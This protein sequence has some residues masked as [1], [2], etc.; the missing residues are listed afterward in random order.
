V[1]RHRPFGS[2]HPYSVDT[3][4]RDPVDPVAGRPLTLGVRVTPE[5]DAVV[6]QWDDGEHVV[7]HPLDRAQRRSR[8]QTVDGGHLASAQARLAR[9]AAASPSI[10]D[11]P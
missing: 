6:L 9:A 8:G 11:C 2:G 5:V 1:I 3:E 4:Q 10:T 7:E